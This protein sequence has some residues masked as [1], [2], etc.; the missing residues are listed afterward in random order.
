MRTAFPCST[1][2]MMAHVSGQSC[3]HAPR[4]VPFV[5][6]GRTAPMGLKDTLAPRGTLSH[7][8]ADQRWTG[9]RA[10]RHQTSAF[11][12]PMRLHAF[13][14]TV[15]ARVA[16]AFVVFSSVATAQ[17]RLAAPDSLT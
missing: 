17:G 5:M 8:D 7:C 6:R 12:H 14:R 10:T 13:I 2:V 15:F 4:T 11:G 3:G 9:P 1:V 16:V